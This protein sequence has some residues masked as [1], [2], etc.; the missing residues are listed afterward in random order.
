M[1]KASSTISAPKREKDPKKQIVITGMGLV[2]VL[3]NDVDSFY[4]KLLNG[5][6]GI[7]LIDKFDASDY[8]VRIA[9]QVLD[10]SAEGYID[11][12]KDQHF[13]DSWRYCLLAAKKALQ[14][15][16]LSP[17]V[18]ETVSSS[19]HRIFTVHQNQLL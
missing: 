7:S 10:F 11:T 16:N 4:D 2:S 1:A 14:E 18:L 9:G 3:G 15:A 8:T 6:S 12:T 17:Q 19:Y 13:D 5:E